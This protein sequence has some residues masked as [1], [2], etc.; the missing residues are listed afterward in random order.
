LYAMAAINIHLL[1]CLM[2][3]VLH[4][5]CLKSLSAYPA[6]VLLCF[7]GVSSSSLHSL[8][9]GAHAFYRSTVCRLFRGY[10]FQMIYQCRWNE[11]DNGHNLF[12]SCGTP[13]NAKVRVRMD[14]AGGSTNTA[15]YIPV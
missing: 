7:A 5:S 15:S 6:P 8:F 9:A 11:V 13:A 4:A 14:T 10:F 2:P 12:E 1:A 3:R